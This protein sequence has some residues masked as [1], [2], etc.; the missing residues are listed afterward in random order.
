MVQTLCLSFG[1]ICLGGQRDA[2]GQD[3][4]CQIYATKTN[5]KVHIHNYCKTGYTGRTRGVNIWLRPVY[6]KQFGPR[7]S[8]WIPVIVGF[9]GLASRVRHAGWATSAR[10]GQDVLYERDVGAVRLVS[11]VVL[12][13]SN[14]SE[15]RQYTRCRLGT[16]HICEHKNM[17]CAYIGRRQTLV[18]V[19]HKTQTALFMS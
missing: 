6:S 7:R 9:Q 1:V 10:H 5:G 3:V 15:Y 8:C 13:K 14:E 18:Y 2:G 17:P 11:V 4:S 16:S 19:I 12:K